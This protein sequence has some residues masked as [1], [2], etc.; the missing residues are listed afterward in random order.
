[1]LRARKGHS[2][3]ISLCTP[4]QG[5]DHLAIARPPLGF[6]LPA[7]G[8]PGVDGRV[9]DPV[10][11]RGRFGSG[12]AFNPTQGVELIENR[13]DL[14]PIQSAHG[15]VAALDISVGN[16]F[17]LVGEDVPRNRRQPVMVIRQAQHARIERQG[18]GQQEAVQERP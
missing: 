11:R 6:S 4:Q 8:E 3:Q 9:D 7:L 2:R 18:V 10:G 12:H 15:L 14:A 17:E 5:G 1:M 13:F 16:P